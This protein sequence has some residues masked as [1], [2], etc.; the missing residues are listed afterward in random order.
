MT[1][2]RKLPTQ[3][4]I[5]TITHNVMLLDLDIITA[6]GIEISATHPDH[7]GREVALVEQTISGDFIAVNA[8]TWHASRM[9]VFGNTGPIHGQSSWY[10]TPL[11]RTSDGAW[12]QNAIQIVMPADSDGT[13]RDTILNF[14]RIFLAGGRL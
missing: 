10:M 11:R 8:P 12:V 6:A 5:D 13:N 14:V 1:T 7:K 4:A 3:Q 9:V 2:S